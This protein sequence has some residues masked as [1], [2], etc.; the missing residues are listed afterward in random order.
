M[1]ESSAHQE[2]GHQLSRQEVRQKYLR[3]LLKK[4]QDRKDHS[5]PGLSDADRQQVAGRIAELRQ[6]P[7][8]QAAD[9]PWTRLD[10]LQEQLTDETQETPNRFIRPKGSKAAAEEPAFSPEAH[11][12]ELLAEMTDSQAEVLKGREPKISVTNLNEQVGKYVAAAPGESVTITLGRN[13]A[14]DVV[15]HTSVASRHQLNI[16]RDPEGFSVVEPLQETKEGWQRGSLNGNLLNGEPLTPNQ[17]VLLKPGD[18]IIMAGI[19]GEAIRFKGY[20]STA[21]FELYQPFYDQR[22]AKAAEILAS[23]EYQHRKE[24]TV[25]NREVA[26]LKTE[27]TEL[28]AERRRQMAVLLL[29]EQL[30]QDI[31]PGY[32]LTRFN[33]HSHS[34]EYITQYV[35]AIGLLKGRNTEYHF[36]SE[37]RPAAG[38]IRMPESASPPQR[39]TLKIISP[40]KAILTFHGPAPQAT[41]DGHVAIS[42]YDHRIV[43]GSIIRFSLNTK[44]SFMYLRGN[45]VPVEHPVANLRRNASAD[46]FTNILLREIVRHLQDETR[47][48]GNLA[49]RAWNALPAPAR[50]V[51]QAAAP[52]LVETFQNELNRYRHQ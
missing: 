49:L 17:K 8:E 35:N 50:A 38:V 18:I 7:Q 10:T 51:I 20:G 24:I 22:S 32:I 33:A 11:L 13:D 4:Y 12:A 40:S 26:T 30:R 25:L 5:K 46:E 14:S 27:N 21:P 9:N 48:V 19:Q 39:S 2:Y 44:E 36:S 43:E 42:R 29:R 34:D 37:D 1:P 31:T 47:T 23:P 3:G 6:N 15:L 45:L 41:V 28:R 16:V 52:K